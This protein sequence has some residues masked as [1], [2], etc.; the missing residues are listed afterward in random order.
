VISV[1]LEEALIRSLE[2]ILDPAEMEQ[3]GFSQSIVKQ[4]IRGRI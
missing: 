2:T 3:M 4:D 1:L